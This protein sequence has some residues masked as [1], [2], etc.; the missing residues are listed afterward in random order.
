MFGG[1]APGRTGMDWC[2]RPR[3]RGH[4]PHLARDPGGAA[5]PAGRMLSAFPQAPPETPGSPVTRPPGVR[6][7]WAWRSPGAAA[8]AP[9]PAPPPGA[10]ARPPGPRPSPR[11][12]PSGPRS[13]PLAPSTPPPS[14]GTNL[15]TAT[16]HGRPRGE[17]SSGRRGPQQQR[18]PCPS[19]RGA[20]PTRAP[21][22]PPPPPGRGPG[23]PSPGL[24]NSHPTRARTR[25]QPC[26]STYLQSLLSS[27]HT[28][29]WK[30]G[31]P[32]GPP[33]PGRLSPQ[34]WAA[35]R[36]R[37]EREAPPCRPLARPPGRPHAGAPAQA[38]R[39]RRCSAGE[40]EPGCPACLLA[41][42]PPARPQPPPPPPLRRFLLPFPLSRLLLRLLWSRG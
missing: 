5:L 26:C 9:A 42:R 21:S 33:A 19:P 3:V 13:P 18:P 15:R 4:R 16:R 1:R 40:S 10:G 31:Q 8:P 29:P 30:P 38:R 7:A 27:H 25:A 22:P 28:M 14:R 35:A 34:P 2:P 11:S 17:T 37:G 20:A 6:P 24:H 32:R 23:V 36:A 41:P 12:I 39:L